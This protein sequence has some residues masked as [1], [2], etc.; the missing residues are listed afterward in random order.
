MRIV[1][2][3]IRLARDLDMETVAEGVENQDQFE[4]LKKLGCDYIQGFML[5]KGFPHELIEQF[6]SKDM[7]R[8]NGLCWIN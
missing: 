7:N 1:Q 6:I 5:S 4:Q 2:T 8:I 3:I